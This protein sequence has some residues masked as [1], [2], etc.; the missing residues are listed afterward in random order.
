[1]WALSTIDSIVLL[2]E[3][4]FSESVLIVGISPEMSPLK[5]QRISGQSI[6]LCTLHSALCMRRQ[7][8]IP[9]AAAR[10][11]DLIDDALEITYALAVGYKMHLE[12]SMLS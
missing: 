5:S 1:M 2:A 12:P 6:G 4:Y 11:L 7:D 9:Q 10:R 3:K 8:C